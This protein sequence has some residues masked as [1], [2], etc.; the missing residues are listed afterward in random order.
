[1]KGF[2]VGIRNDAF[3]SCAWNR[4]RADGFRQHA[5]GQS[6]FEGGNQAGWTRHGRERGTRCP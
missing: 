1:M 5:R 6:S 3:R 2:V 4:I